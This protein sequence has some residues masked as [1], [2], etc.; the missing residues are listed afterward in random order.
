MVAAEAHA[1]PEPESGE[2][3]AE[4]GST[5]EVLMEV[6]AEDMKVGW[7]TSLKSQLY[8]LSGVLLAGVTI[9]MIVTVVSLSG[10]GATW[11]NKSSKEIDNVQVSNM[12]A[13]TYAKSVYVKVPFSY[14]AISANMFMSPITY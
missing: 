13:I 8:M 10:Q 3:M 11:M 14:F 4:V 7:F 2:D 1:V 5:D 12:E 6:P 9:T